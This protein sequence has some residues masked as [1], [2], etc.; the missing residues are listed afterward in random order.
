[1]GLAEWEA[2][3]RVELAGE[4]GHDAAPSPLLIAAAEGLPP[5][6]ALDLGCGR[7]RHAL[8][9]AERG[10]RVTAVDGSPAAISIVNASAARRGVR[11]DARVADLEEGEFAIKPASWELIAS[12]YYLQRDL[13]DPIK[14]GLVS[15]GIAIVIALMAKSQYRVQPGELRSHFAGWEVLHDREGSDPSGH[16]VAEI[17]AR[18]P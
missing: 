18:K 10:W 3:Y 7:G 8:W 5:A 14:E 11:L 17:V 16:A 12:C 6:R 1:M 15:G 4:T 2:R 9:L 13:L